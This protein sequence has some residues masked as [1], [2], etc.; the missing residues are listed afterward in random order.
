[1]KSCEEAILLPLAATRKK[2]ASVRRQPSD[3][4]VQLCDRKG[5]EAFKNLPGMVSVMSGKFRMERQFNCNSD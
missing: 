3:V 5:F 1:L 4:L 2:A